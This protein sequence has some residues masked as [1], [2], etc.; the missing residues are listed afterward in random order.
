MVI[1]IS[2]PV[3]LKCPDRSPICL[4]LDKDGST[5]CWVVSFLLDRSLSKCISC[6]LLI[7]NINFIT[8][9]DSSLSSSS[10]CL[11]FSCVSALS[12]SISYWV[13]RITDGIGS[14]CCQVQWLVFMFIFMLFIISSPKPIS[15]VLCKSFFI[16]ATLFFSALPSHW[17]VVEFPFLVQD[18]LSIKF[19]KISKL[20]ENKKKTNLFFFLDVFFIASKRKYH[21]SNIINKEE[22]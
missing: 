2:P 19:T 8:C 18:F 14:P 20:I 1:L 22:K 11:L 9:M 5:S 12:P 15:M 6:F 3:S 17:F 13:Q 4:G 16:L 7:G 10:S 21:Y